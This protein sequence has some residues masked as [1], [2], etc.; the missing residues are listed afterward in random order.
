MGKGFSGGPVGRDGIR[1]LSQGP[2]HP[3]SCGASS[4]RPH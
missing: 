1:G 2:E 3:V 4:S